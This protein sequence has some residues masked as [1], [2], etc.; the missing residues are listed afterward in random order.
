MLKNMMLGYLLMLEMIL[1]V[2][3]VVIVIVVIVIVIVI[4]FEILS[5]RLKME[6]S[7]T[8]KKRINS[9]CW[10]ISTC[11]FDLNHLKSPF[12]TE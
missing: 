8:C 12:L 4:N 9:K 2:V 5:V 6:G 1:I 11:S 7:K 10:N 3:V